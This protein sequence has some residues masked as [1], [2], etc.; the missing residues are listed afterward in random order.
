[1]TPVPTDVAVP[2]G[3]DVLEVTAV[4]LR[5]GSREVLAAL[6]LTVAPGEV[7]ALMGLSG[8]GKTTALRAIAG[9]ETFDAG[10]IPDDPRSRSA[11]TAGA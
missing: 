11:V 6:T 3:L 10:A 9:L 2:E 1:M 5:R 4:R 8:S 7:V